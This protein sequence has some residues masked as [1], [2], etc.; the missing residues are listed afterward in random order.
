MAALGTERVTYTL[1]T[2]GEPRPDL[3][4]STKERGPRNQALAVMQR[5]SCRPATHEGAWHATWSRAAEK[6]K[7]TGPLTSVCR[8]RRVVSAAWAKTL[9]ELARHVQVA[10]GRGYTLLPGFSGRGW[11]PMASW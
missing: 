3:R 2:E 5:V 7:A 11:D 8:R 1:A 4:H 6:D 9:L 10:L